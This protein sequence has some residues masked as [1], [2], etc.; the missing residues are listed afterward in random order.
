MVSPIESHIIFCFWTEDNEMSKNRLI[1]LQC[2]INNCKCKVVLVNTLNLENFILKDHPLHPAYQYLSATHKSDYLRTYFMNFYGGGYSDVK[3]T[4]ASWKEHFDDL[5]NS[6]KWVCGYPE[7]E[8]GVGYE[9][10]N[11]KW[12]DLVG[13]GCYICKPN[14]PFTNEWYNEMIK[15]LDEKLELLKE[16]PATN[17]RDCFENSKKYPIKWVEMLGRIFHQYNYKYKEKFSNKLPMCICQN[18]T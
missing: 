15:L 10:L 3:G 17:A 2:L 6:D 9:P 11:D 5:L 12:R 4:R 14:T 13:N 8:G 16:N 1:H 18:Y 7:I